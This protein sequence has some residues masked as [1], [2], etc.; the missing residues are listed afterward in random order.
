[1]KKNCKNSLYNQKRFYTRGQ[2]GEQKEEKHLMI[3]NRGLGIKVPTPFGT[4]F[5]LM[6]CSV[7]Q[8]MHF[9]YYAETA[10]SND[11]I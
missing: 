2:E 1:M 10:P 4:L 5:A 7:M 8:I 9:F 3:K 11:P 6:F